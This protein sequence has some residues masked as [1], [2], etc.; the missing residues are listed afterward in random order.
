MRRLLLIATLLLSLVLCSRAH[1]ENEASDRNIVLAGMAMGIPTYMLGVSVHEGSHALFGKLVGAEII[2]YSL[3][4]GFHPQTGKFYFGYVTV[5]GL[6]TDQQRA[7]FLIAPKV[8]DSLLLGGYTALW[9]TGSLPSN[10][11]A[12]TA[13]LVL[14]TGFWV[15]FTRDVF[16]WWD[17]NDTVKVYNS[18]G[19][20]SELKRLPARLLHLGISAAWAYGIYRGYDELFADGSASGSTALEVQ[21][22]LLPLWDQSF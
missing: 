22:L 16:A 11:Y 9:A 1:A 3:I 7:W 13:V 12:R 5:M 18:L 15:D 6:R 21:P 17:H 20:D 19:L 10:D 4:P 8:S 2:D 14:A